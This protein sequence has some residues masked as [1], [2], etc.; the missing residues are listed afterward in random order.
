MLISML[1]VL[2]RGCRCIEIDVWNGEELDSP[3]DRLV[4]KAEEKIQSL[5]SKISHV[6]APSFSGSSLTVLDRDGDRSSRHLKHRKTPSISTLAAS[7][8][9]QDISLN[10][11]ASTRSAS[12]NS[13]TSSQKN[14][15]QPRVLHGWTLTSEV[16]FRDVCKAIM[17]TGFQN[18]QLPII[19]SLEVHADMQ[20][21]ETMVEIMKEEWHGRMVDTAHVCNPEERLPRLDELLGKILV[22]VK[23]GDNP[24]PKAEPEPNPKSS[25]ASLAPS[26]YHDLGDSGLSG[27]ED[28]RGGK[29]KAKKSKICDSL[30]KLGIYTRST[31]FYDFDHRNASV[32][33]HIFSISEM[34][35][36]KLHAT[37]KSE[38]FTHNRNYFMRAYPAGKRI[39]SSNLDPSV[40]WRK[41]VQMV[42]LNWQSLDEGMMLNEG[43]F[44]GEKGWLLK[45][46]GYL[47]EDDTHDQTEA[48]ERMTMD[49]TIKVL[50]AQDIPLVDQNKSPK[51][52]HPYIKCELHVETEEERTGQP[53]E[54]AGK[55]KDGL[56]KRKTQ[57]RKGQECNWNGEELKFEGIEDIVEELSFLRLVPPIV[58]R[59]YTCLFREGCYAAEKL[60]TGYSSNERN[61]CSATSMQEEQILKKRVCNTNKREEKIKCNYP[62]QV[63]LN[64]YPST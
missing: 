41:G 52:F 33:P 37:K 63:H 5:V 54:N 22:K 39:D 44:A 26:S 51:G 45:P 30:S 43:M 23:Q 31:H 35:I 64:K 21:Q 10:E 50:A 49:L 34:D 1:K 59:I 53:I 62:S 19:V 24:K 11:S 27:S 4:E 29:K 48:V 55:V 61:L 16:S 9:E 17:E 14:A 12:A 13:N 18:S 2:L 42:A 7:D 56:Y 47:S 6:K 46:K 8:D 32:P 60:I 36:L 58:E 38:M 25:L 20:Q 28:E 57:S 3:S 40:Y 15:P